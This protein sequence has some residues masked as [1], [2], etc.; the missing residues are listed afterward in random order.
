MLS[1][2]RVI[3]ICAE[4]AMMRHWIEIVLANK[5]IGILQTLEDAFGLITKISSLELTPD[6]QGRILEQEPLPEHYLHWRD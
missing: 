3:E 2:K 4:H 6:Q 5:S 1:E